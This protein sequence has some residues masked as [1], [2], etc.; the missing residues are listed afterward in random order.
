MKKYYLITIYFVSYII[1]LQ[2][3]LYLMVA[4]FW[5]VMLCRGVSRT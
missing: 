2:V 5:D 4:V 1:T 3:I